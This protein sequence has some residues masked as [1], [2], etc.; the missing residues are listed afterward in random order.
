MVRV[1][2]LVNPSQ[3]GNHQ[4]SVLR[5]KETNPRFVLRLPSFQHAHLS[6]IAQRNRRSMNAEIH[7]LLERHISTHGTAGTGAPHTLLPENTHH[8]ELA[9][10][11]IP[12]SLEKKRALLAL[13]K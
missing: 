6:K 3:N 2:R 9:S 13:L 8:R 4:P 7:R 12:L 11:F 1:I 5:G 10:K